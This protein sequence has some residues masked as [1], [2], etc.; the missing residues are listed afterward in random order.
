MH[1]CLMFSKI[2]SYPENLS[3]MSNEQYFP[4]PKQCF[5]IHSFSHL[6]HSQYTKWGFIR[7]FSPSFSS[8]SAKS[9]IKSR[10]RSLLLVYQISYSTLLSGL[11]KLNSTRIEIYA[12]VSA[13]ALF[14]KSSNFAPCS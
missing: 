8:R 2:I 7:I 14:M 10:T 6:R 12:F 1:F 11:L 13:V 9:D 5:S 3:Y 4:P